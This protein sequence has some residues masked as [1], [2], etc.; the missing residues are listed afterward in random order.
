[1][2]ISLT[3]QLTKHISAEYR[4]ELKLVLGRLNAWQYN[5][6]WNRDKTQIIQS[7]KVFRHMNWKVK[8]TLK[9]G[10][11]KSVKMTSHQLL[12]RNYLKVVITQYNQDNL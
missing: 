10:F 12:K 3:N 7:V 1:M 2:N 8:M 9:Y 4:N 11:L 5:A 6:D